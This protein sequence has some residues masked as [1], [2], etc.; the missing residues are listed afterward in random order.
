MDTGQ[1]DDIRFFD[2]NSRIGRLRYLAYGLGL[3]LLGTLGILVCAVLAKVT[4]T[5]GFAAGGVIYIGWIVMSIAF[6]VRRLHDLDKSGWWVL[7]MLVPLVNLLLVLYML[8]AGGSD[9]ENRFGPVPPPNSGWV[10]AGAVAYI[11]LIPV[12][13]ILAAIAIP[14]YQDFV[15]RSQTSEGIQLAGGAEVPVSEY[16][17]SN[18]NGP[19]DLSAIYSVA[20]QNPAGRYVATVTGAGSGNTYGVVSTMSTS[21]VNA[22]I[23][24][25]SLEIW[26]TDGGNT[27]YCGPG[28]QDPVDTKFLPASCRDPSAP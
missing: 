2:L 5:L 25:R 9:G 19:A 21:G 8:F 17:K 22:H 10:I 3:A 18:K 23:A 15:A 27:W 20:G 14:A 1:A 28:G 11:A 6:G 7:L 26:T 12:G 4:A 24:G 13:G 16:F